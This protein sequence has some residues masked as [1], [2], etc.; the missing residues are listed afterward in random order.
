MAEAALDGPAPAAFKAREIPGT[1]GEVHEEY[2]PG[3]RVIHADES[4]AKPADHLHAT[5][6]STNMEVR[7]NLV[8]DEHKVFCLTE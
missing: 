2:K 3:T 7:R 5:I 6:I 4:G 8:L 1:K